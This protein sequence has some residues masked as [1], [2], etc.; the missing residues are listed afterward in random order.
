MSILIP[1]NMTMG[2]I[3]RHCKAKAK[4]RE[5]RQLKLKADLDKNQKMIDDALASIHKEINAQIDK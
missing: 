5:A 3:E 4:R 1:N 2:E